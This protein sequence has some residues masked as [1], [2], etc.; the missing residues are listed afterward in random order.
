MKKYLLSLLLVPVLLSNAANSVYAEN[1]TPS[2]SGP[3]AASGAPAYKSVFAV[4]RRLNGTNA[5]AAAIQANR[6][7]SVE[8]RF[9]TGEAHRG[10][11]LY[12]E[13]IHHVPGRP[14]Q[15]MG[16][17]RF[18]LKDAAG[19]DVVHNGLNYDDYQYSIAHLK[20]DYIRMWGDL[21]YLRDGAS[22]VGTGVSMYALWGIANWLSTREVR[23][24][25]A[26]ALK[27][28]QLYKN[29]VGFAIALIP[30]YYAAKA[31]YQFYNTQLDHA[32]KGR[33][34]AERTW[35]MDTMSQAY[36]NAMYS[37]PIDER[38]FDVEA[39]YNTLH[40]RLTNASHPA[41]AP[42]ST[43]ERRAEAQAHPAPA[44]AVNTIPMSHDMGFAVTAIQNFFNR[45]VEANSEDGTDDGNPAEAPAQ[46]TP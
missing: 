2:P 24:L 45:Y 38:A 41:P 42:Q 25:S 3:S 10:G 40:E 34:M 4:P 6:M 14:D 17:T 5:D 12:F 43:E 36:E 21:I 20:R 26:A 27:F 37:V 18:V 31:V 9:Y 33:E 39:A 13:A 35:L 15:S 32:A 8:I 46:P 28:T 16:G 30:T 1:N 44:L 7:E 29:P 22:I 23:I 19:R 11:G